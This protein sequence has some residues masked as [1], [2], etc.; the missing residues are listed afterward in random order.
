V[1]ASAGLPAAPLQKDH[2]LTARTRTAT[3]A[4]AARQALAA[5]KPSA[6][7]A[8]GIA[9][10]AAAG[11]IAVTAAAPWASAATPAPATRDQAVNAAAPAPAGLIG[12]PAT[13]AATH[14]ATAGTAHAAAGT[15]HAAAK[16]PAT[17]HAAAKHTGAKHSAATHAAASAKPSV[18]YDSVTPSSI[19]AG[20]DAAV[21]ADGSYQATTAQAASHKHV[22]WIDT[23]G[24]RTDADVLDVEPGDATP[25][26]AA[27]WVKAKLTKDPAATAIVYTFKANW[28]PTTT[29]ISALPKAMQHH[30]KYWI[31]D[32]TGTP[33]I[34]P[35][36]EA[37]QWYWGPNY[38][39]ST[40]NP[41][42]NS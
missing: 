31:A 29:A 32:P 22:L 12:Q 41:G 28:A 34:L 17:T 37:T 27:T 7:W 15:T 38:D 11:A 10:T 1:H 42:F 33:H 3:A 30:V 2:S 6:R 26:G 23:N 4:S 8:A 40:A 39:I 5:T 14:A 18:I 13:H 36:A 16:H 25:A 21:Y 9:A 24:S 35:G 20:K 19:P